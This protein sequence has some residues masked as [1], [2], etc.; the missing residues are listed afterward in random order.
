MSI[1]LRFLKFTH[2]ADK[3]RTSFLSQMNRPD[4]VSESHLKFVLKKI[5]F[6]FVSLKPYHELWGKLRNRY[7]IRI[8]NSLP[9]LFHN[10]FN[11]RNF[12]DDIDLLNHLLSFGLF[13]LRSLLVLPIFIASIRLDDRVL[14]QIALGSTLTTNNAS[15]CQRIIVVTVWI[16]W[17]PYLFL[18]LP[19]DLALII[20][21]VVKA[22]IAFV[23]VVDFSNIILVLNFH[24]FITEN[25]WVFKIWLDI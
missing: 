14:G 13:P 25:A 9:K 8:T 20:V 15:G 4:K 12:F 7:F 24:W 21:E 11:A 5:R 3:V 10:V 6:T 19:N 2:I 16:W 23:L 17:Y 22:I 1:C 18:L